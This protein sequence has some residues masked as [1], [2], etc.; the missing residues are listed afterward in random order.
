[1]ADVR[2]IQKL[3][4]RIEEE[5]QKDKFYM[6]SW[7]SVSDK[8]ANLLEALAEDGAVEPIFYDDKMF[9]PLEINLCG[10]AACAA[11]WALIEE[12]YT[13]V[14]NAY[15]DQVDFVK[16]DDHVCNGDSV[17]TRAAEILGIEDP[18]EFGHN[19]HIFT[20]T[21]WPTSMVCEGLRWLAK[22]ESMDDALE[23]A[24]YSDDV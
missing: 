16:D 4:D 5:A 19:N 2:K 24:E 23:I 17:G 20:K 7:A 12:G 11:G 1:M 22:G 13:P 6:G 10:F 21:S 3:I 14:Y 15:D 9:V 8:G 18:Y